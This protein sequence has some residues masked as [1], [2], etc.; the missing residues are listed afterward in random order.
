M[1]SFPILLHIVFVVCTAIVP[2]FS[3]DTLMYIG[4][5]NSSSPPSSTLNTTAPMCSPGGSSSS[6]ISRVRSMPGAMGRG[7]GYFM[8]AKGKPSI[9][10]MTSKALGAV[11]EIEIL[12]LA[13]LPLRTPPRGSPMEMNRPEKLIH[14]TSCMVGKP[15]SIMF[16]SSISSLRGRMLLTASLLSTHRFEES[17]GCTR[18]GRSHF[19]APKPASVLPNR[20]SRSSTAFGSYRPIALPIIRAISLGVP[21]LHS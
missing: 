19:H 17:I 18:E 14:S 5:L 15:F 8:E 3:I 7:G 10:L 13:G 4:H 21:P 9:L 20:S 2:P 1:A 11:F 16:L 12:N 6:K